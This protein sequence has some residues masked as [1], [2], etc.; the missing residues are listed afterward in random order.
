MGKDSN[1]L[2][3]EE[4]LKNKEHPSKEKA[5]KE[6]I[7]IRKERTIE[8]YQ[9]MVDEENG[10]ITEEDTNKNPEEKEVKTEVKEPSVVPDRYK[11]KTSEELIKLL[12][13]KEK[14]IQGRSDE[15]GNLRQEIKKAEVLKAKIDEIESKTIKQSQQMGNMPKPP[16]APVINEDDFYSDPI[17]TYKA[18]LDY[19]KKLIGYNQQYTHAMVSPFYQADAEAKRE[20]LYKGLEDKYKDYPVRFDRNKVQEFLNNNPDY[21]TKYGINAYENAYHDISTEDYSEIRAKEKEEIKEQIRKEVE[22]E[23]RTKGQAGNMGFGDLGSQPI[24]PTGKAPLYDEQ[25]M[26]DDPEYRDQVIKDI[27]K[28]NR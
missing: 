2:K 25:R 6:P 8:E 4:A 28:R 18:I 13:E 27:E 16:E 22:E 12:D 10:E 1:T 21:F 14:Y 23:I 20:K 24:N 7:D 19:N 17:K 26:E 5:V 9:R 3:K 11:G 15:I